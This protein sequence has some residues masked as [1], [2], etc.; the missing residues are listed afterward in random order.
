MSFFSVNKTQLKDDPPPMDDGNVAQ[1]PMDRDTE[2]TRP[3]RRDLVPVMNNIELRNFLLAN[4]DIF[5]AVAS[6]PD[7]RI[8]E[9]VWNEVSCA[10]EIFVELW[11][12]QPEGRKRVMDMVE[13]MIKMYSAIAPEPPEGAP[14]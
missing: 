12:F 2:P 8:E 3:H 5:R 4:A 7:R 14:V 10:R 13:N 11:Q 9:S 1:F 6:L